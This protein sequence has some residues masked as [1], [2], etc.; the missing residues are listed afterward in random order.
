MQP[1]KRVKIDPTFYLIERK[2]IVF[3]KFDENSSL[4][5]T[6]TDIAEAI[7]KPA[8]INEY[9]LN[10][11]SLLRAKALGYTCNRVM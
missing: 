2:I 10:E 6:L 11:T 3:A 5:M 8:H 1:N 9:E 4:N 7:S